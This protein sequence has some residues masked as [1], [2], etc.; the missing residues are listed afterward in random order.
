MKGIL[1]K[2]CF[3][4]ESVILLFMFIVLLIQLTAIVALLSAYPIRG[5]LRHQD[6]SDFGDGMEYSY[7]QGADAV[8]SR[9][10]TAIMPKVASSAARDL[11]TQDLFCEVFGAY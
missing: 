5:I 6:K 10:P 11:A 3:L 4:S 7:I 9:G 2:I 1:V 8:Y